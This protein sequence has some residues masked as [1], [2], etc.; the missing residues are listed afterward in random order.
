MVGVWGVAAQETIA[1]HFG[2]LV[3]SVGWKVEEEETAPRYSGIVYSGTLVRDRTGTR[4]RSTWWRVSLEK[5][6]QGG[7]APAGLMSSRTECGLSKSE[8]GKICGP[9]MACTIAPLVS[10]R[11]CH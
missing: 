8:T 4:R 9:K 7:S 5:E 10:T 2:G 6:N 1:G 11:V 3:Y